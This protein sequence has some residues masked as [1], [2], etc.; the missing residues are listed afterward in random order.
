MTVIIRSSSA[1]RTRALIGPCR[2]HYIYKTV[3]RAI[4]ESALITWIGL[5]VY[6]ITAALALWANSHA[7]DHVSRLPDNTENAWLAD[8]KTGCRDIFSGFNHSSIHFCESG[9]FLSRTDHGFLPL[10]LLRNALG[11]VSELDH[12]THWVLAPASSLPGSKAN[13]SRLCE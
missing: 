9:S 2:D 12:R 13:S 6:V 7:A 8:F 3:I 5:L 10:I 4:I 1:N 11:H